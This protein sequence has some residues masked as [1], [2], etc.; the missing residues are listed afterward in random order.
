M[1][2]KESIEDTA[3]AAAACLTALSTAASASASV[4][5]L[6]AVRLRPGLERADGRVS[7]DAD[8]RRCLT[9]QEEHFGHWRT[10]NLA[11]MGDARQ[12]HGQRPSWSA[13]PRWAIL[14]T[15]WRPRPTSPDAQLIAGVWEA[16]PSRPDG[17]DAL[18]DR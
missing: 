12:Q 13:A 7:P 2:K 14:C 4:E 6:A 9:M 15:A 16:R 5:E 10:S 18:G 8:P 1:G 3:R 11:F 17:R